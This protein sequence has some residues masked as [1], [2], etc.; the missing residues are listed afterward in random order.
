MVK[1]SVSSAVQALIDADISMQDAIE[2]GYANYSAIARI[3][4]PQ[5][6]EVLE[7]PTKIESIITAVKRA[8]S[9]VRTS[10][11]SIASIV[12]RSVVNLRTDV[13]KI[14]VEKT[15]RT[16]QIV[17]RTMADL[18]GEFLQILEGV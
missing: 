18:R 8:R 6:E 14:S 1:D 7:R 3:L 12:S 11:A 9:T 4:R 13:A 2:R 15:R 17:R 10:Q 5:V 16:V